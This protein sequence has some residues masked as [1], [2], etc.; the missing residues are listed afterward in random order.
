MGISAFL[1]EPCES[2]DRSITTRFEKYIVADE[3]NTLEPAFVITA[4]I[5]RS[6]IMRAYQPVGADETSHPECVAGAFVEERHHFRF[7]LG[8]QRFFH[9]RL[10]PRG[11]ESCFVSLRCIKLSQ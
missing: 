4:G 8:C 7:V 5:E 1:R 9:Q 2:L 10:A 3:S 6:A 11:P